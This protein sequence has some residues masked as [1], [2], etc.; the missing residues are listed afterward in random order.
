MPALNQANAEAFIKRLQ[1]QEAA[2][3]GGQLN[4][5]LIHAGLAMMAGQ[6]PNAL[7]NVAAGGI[8]GLEAYQ[9]SG[10]EQQALA[11][12]IGALQM[13]MEKDAYAGD[14]KKYDAKQQS[15]QKALDRANT[16]ENTR[17]QN[18]NRLAI[19]QMDA[20]VKQASLAAQRADTMTQKQMFGIEKAYDST[21]SQIAALNERLG[22]LSAGDEEKAA[23]REQVATLVQ[24][25][26]ALAQQA[27]TLL[28]TGNLP[29]MPPAPT[30]GGPPPGAVR[31]IR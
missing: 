13:G 12:K 31:E 14:W 5:A 27:S 1:E 15:L 28:G 11:E 2:S 6:S 21:K 23:I 16:L 10:K 24:H 4:N 25:Q 9:S 20:Q 19:A 3:K 29:T 7:T 18:A 30:A 22:S 17:L 8:A 26:Q